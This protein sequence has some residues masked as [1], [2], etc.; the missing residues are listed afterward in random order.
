MDVGLCCVATG[1]HSTG[2]FIHRSAQFAEQ[3]GFASYWLGDHLMLFGSY[4]DSPYPYAG[5]LFGDP[6]MP[7]PRAP[8]YEPLMG[9]CWAAAA[10][11]RIGIGSGVIILPQRHPVVLAKQVSCLDELSEGRVTLGV[12]LG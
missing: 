1:A 7:D 5:E 4:P 10:T 11:S 9:M 12:G 2:E 6:P 8:L 3:S